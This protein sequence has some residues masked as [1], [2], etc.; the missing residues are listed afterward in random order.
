MATLNEQQKRFVVTRLACFYS[1][2]EVR[3]LAKE[4]LGLSLELGQV[5]S[6]DPTTVLG[7]RL[8][9]ELKSLFEETRREFQGNIQAIPIAN[10]SYRLRELQRLYRNTGKN[11]VLGAQLLEQAAKE[12]GGMFTNRREVTGKDGKP[13]SHQVEQFSFDGWDIEELDA[14]NAGGMPAVNELR[15]RRQEEEPGKS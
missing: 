10:Q 13:I 5:S 11:S 1:P 8:S 7:G 12:A 3:D 4:E 6:Y 2:S 9:K 15:R 14:Y